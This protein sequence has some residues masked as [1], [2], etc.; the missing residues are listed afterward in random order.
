MPHRLEKVAEI[1]GVVTA[2]NC[3]AGETVDAINKEVRR[4][5]EEVA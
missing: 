2:V 4:I 1:D 5:A 3:R